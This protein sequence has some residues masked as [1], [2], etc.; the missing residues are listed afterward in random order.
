MCNIIKPI[1]E[2]VLTPVAVETTSMAVLQQLL[3]EEAQHSALPAWGNLDFGELDGGNAKTGVESGLDDFPTGQIS[4]TGTR[5]PGW[6][7][8]NPRTSYNSPKP[9]PLNFSLK[10]PLVI[11]EQIGPRSSISSHN[12]PPPPPFLTCFSSSFLPSRSTLSPSKPVTPPTHLSLVATSVQPKIN[13]K[14]LDMRS[15]G[16]RRLWRQGIRRTLST[17]ASFDRLQIA[18]MFK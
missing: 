9:G 10:R 7:S 17:T 1:L 18:H 8:W 6:R 11:W 13:L 14:K 4:W 3:S 5:S 12:I 2:R 16:K 15:V